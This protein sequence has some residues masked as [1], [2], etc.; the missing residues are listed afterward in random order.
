LKS[1]N[2]TVVY[3]FSG[4]GADA[5]IFRKLD[6]GNLPVRHIA[7]V[8]PKNN[9]TLTGY[10]TRLS[11]QIES[12]HPILIGV[13]FGGMLA[14]EISKTIDCERVILIYSAKNEREIPFL[15]RMAGLMRLHR[16][17]PV[18]VLKSANWFVSNTRRC[19]QDFTHKKH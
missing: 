2:E 8:K 9:E 1:H 5:R 16:L 4:L 6:F 19:R 7:W 3:L 11:G 13:S 17:I 14:I 18:K 15:Y 12:S 10:A